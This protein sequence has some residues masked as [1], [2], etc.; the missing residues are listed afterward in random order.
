MYS[1][2]PYKIRSTEKKIFFNSAACGFTEKLQEQIS[3]KPQLLNET[4]K[5]TKQKAI[6]Y[7]LKNRH[8]DT[9]ILLYTKG[10]SFSEQELQRHISLSKSPYKDF[11]FFLKLSEHIPLALDGKRGNEFIEYIFNK[12]KFIC[13]KNN[14]IVSLEKIHEEIKVSP[15]WSKILTEYRNYKNVGKV[16]NPSTLQFIRDITLKYLL[17][18]L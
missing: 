11:L 8:L 10:Q 17:D 7:S 1:N 6:F 4:N 18:E 13:Y 2:N 5:D 9:T 14:D 16:T 12:F 15:D 3:K